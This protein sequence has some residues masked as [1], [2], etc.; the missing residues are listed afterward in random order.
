MPVQQDSQS[1]DY[2]GLSSDTKPTAGMAPGIQFY[3]TDTGATY[4]YTGSAWVLKPIGAGG[5]QT[6]AGTVTVA[7]SGYGA[8]VTVTRPN[9]TT[10]YTAGDV[11]GAAAA[12][13]TFPNMGP[14]G[15]EI[16]LTSTTLEVDVAAIPSGMTS[17]TLRLYSATP[18]SAYADN[19]VWD[20]PAGDRASYLGHINLGTPVD[21]GSTLRVAVDGI[22]KQLKLAAASTSLYGYLISDSGF[23]PSASTVKLIGLHAVA[24]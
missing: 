12:A 21:L 13:L 11:V 5:T 24:L 6:I 15:G 7:P 4:I 16:M 3:E 17:F 18:P 8:T 1:Q 19:A 2:I 20:L 22:N 9:D 14:A 23:T 10:P